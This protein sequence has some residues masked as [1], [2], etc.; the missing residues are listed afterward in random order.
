MVF[1]FSIKYYPKIYQRN[2]KSASFQNVTK[3][4]FIMQL[5]L[6]QKKIF[7]IRG[8]KVMLDFDLA[9]LYEVGTKVLNQAVKRNMERF[10]ER[11]MF[12]LTV[13]EWKNIRSQIV[14]ASLQSK[15]NIRATPFV[16]SEHGVTMLASVLRSKKAVNMNIAIVEAFIALKEFALTY[17]ELAEKIRKVERKNSKQF[18]DVYKA[19]KYLMDE[20]QNGDNWK[21]RKQIGFISKWKNLF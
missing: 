3:I 8:Q 5:Q 1:Y 9:D 11:F 18:S 21:K 2:I 15:R 6:I 16:F 13:K 17:K 10:P 12:R 4:K 14:T 19:L 7:E 20:K